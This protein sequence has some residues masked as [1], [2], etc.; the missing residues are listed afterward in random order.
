VKT[1][2]L[3]LLPSPLIDL[4]PHE[5]FIFTGIPIYLIEGFSKGK[6]RPNPTDR[7]KLTKASIP[8]YQWS[9]A[10]KRAFV[11]RRKYRTV[12][13][14]LSVEEKESLFTDPRK[15]EKKLDEYVLKYWDQIVIAIA[16][17]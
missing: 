13:S 3:N 8:F 11:V 10:E 1:Q 6:F 5:I 9:D 4:S 7:E 12:R 14:F 15:Y 17:E 2:N 16:G